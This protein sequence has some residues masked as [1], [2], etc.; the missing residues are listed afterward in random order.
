MINCN[1]ATPV[2]GLCSKELGEAPL[3]LASAARSQ[4]WQDVVPIMQLQASWAS[5]THHLYHRSSILNDQCYLVKNVVAKAERMERPHHYMQ[6][7]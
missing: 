7:S 3:D 1:I 5:R 4:G 6:E 2:K